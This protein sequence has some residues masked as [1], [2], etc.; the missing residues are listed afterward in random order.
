[1]RCA[2]M[3]RLGLV[4]LV[5]A[6]IR[7]VDVGLCVQS[8]GSRACRSHKVAY[9]GNCLGVQD[10][11]A[12]FWARLAILIVCDGEL[13]DVVKRLLACDAEYAFIASQYLFTPSIQRRVSITVARG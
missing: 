3:R 11:P 8:S 9:L 5:W 12:C 13:E 1:M 4:K 7:A 6:E 2:M 10:C